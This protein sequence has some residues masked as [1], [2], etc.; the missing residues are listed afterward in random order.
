MKRTFEIRVTV[1][2][3]GRAVKDPIGQIRDILSSNF[4][5]IDKPRVKYIPLITEIEHILPLDEC[6]GY[7]QS[8]I[9]EVADE[10]DDEF[11]NDDEDPDEA[12]DI[13]GFTGKEIQ[14]VWNDFKTMDHYHVCQTMHDTVQDMLAAK[15]KERKVA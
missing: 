8:F 15:R 6:F 11:T 9:G 5:S 1:E 7:D 10:M 3:D 2:Y 14:D 13:E 12:G 4:I